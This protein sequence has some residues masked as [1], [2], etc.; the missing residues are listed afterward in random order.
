[1]TKNLEQAYQM[2]EEVDG[3]EFELVK[4]D[5]WVCSYNVG[6]FVIFYSDILNY[7]RIGPPFTHFQVSVLS[8]LGVCQAQLT[9]NT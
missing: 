8:L 1:M 3:V 6:H 4:A 2:K 7:L 5:E 9:W